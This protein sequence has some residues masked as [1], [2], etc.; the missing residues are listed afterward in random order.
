MY[1]LFAHLR[2]VPE[3]SMWKAIGGYVIPHWHIPI[4]RGM[5][6]SVARP[7]IYKTLETT[8]QWLK[9]SAKEWALHNTS[10]PPPQTPTPTHIYSVYNILMILI[11]VI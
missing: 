6:V 11:T 7:F 10:H 5:G 2:P 3:M 9:M 4:L 8:L 1:S